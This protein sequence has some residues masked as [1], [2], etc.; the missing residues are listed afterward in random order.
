M[1]KKEIYYHWRAC[2][3]KAEEKLCQ[4]VF[5][6]ICAH[7]A[8]SHRHYH[9]LEHIAALL[10]Q[11]QSLD[12]AKEERELLIQAAIFHDVIYSPGSWLNEV[13][14]SVYA[15]VKLN[16]LQWD[17]KSIHQV[18]EL[19]EET[20]KHESDQPLSELFIDLDLMVLASRPEQ[21][22]VYRQRI[23]K[24]HQQIP[25]MLYK[26]GRKRFLK[27]MLTKVSIFQSPAF[28]RKYELQARKN[29][30]HELKNL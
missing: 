8:Q 9:N 22:Q 5:K 24:E 23:R 13:K 20:A 17:S 11:I 14:S 1:E 29:M 10:E 19:I 4:A 7:Y 30:I 16:L 12:L 27:G 15:N 21:Y 2:F 28:R 25:N 26:I 6:D 3:P 18:C